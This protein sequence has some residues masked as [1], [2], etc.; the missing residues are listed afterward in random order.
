MYVRCRE[1]VFFNFAIWI[2]FWYTR[3]WYLDS[4]A[5]LSYFTEYEGLPNCIRSIQFYKESMQPSYFFHFLNFFWSVFALPGPVDSEPVESGSNPD[6]NNDIEGCIW[7]MLPIWNSLNVNAHEGL[8]L[9]LVLENGA[10]TACKVYERLFLF[11]YS[12]FRW[13]VLKRKYTEAQREV[14]KIA[15]V[16]VIRIQLYHWHA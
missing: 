7:T 9:G 15:R 13:L 6:H 11:F 14:E 12:T 4:M 2:S 3:T 16:R 1:S 8:K 5:R 10:P